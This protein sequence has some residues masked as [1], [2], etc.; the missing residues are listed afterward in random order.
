MNG[1][2]VL[3]RIRARRAAAQSSD[4]L[5]ARIQARRAAKM[6][7]R[8]A[9][10]VTQTRLT[11]PRPTGE[12][13][14]AIREDD[15]GLIATG[16]QGA[17]F[18]LSDEFLAGVKSLGGDQTYAQAL[19][20]E[21][22][23]L[24][25]FRQRHP[26]GSRVTEFAGAATTAGPLLRGANVLLRGALGRGSATLQAAKAGAVGGAAYGA[27]T[28]D[29]DATASLEE[30][31]IRRAGGAAVGGVIGGVAGG[32]V[33]KGIEKA[34]PLVERIARRVRGQPV[35]Q[36]TAPAV[37]PV[38]DKVADY[39][40]KQAGRD[41]R[42][43]T[44][45][46]E[47]V[48]A[49][50][51]LTGTPETIMEMSGPAMRRAGRAVE[52]FPGPGASRMARFAE[53]R[54]R[55][56]PADAVADMEKIMGRATEDTYRLTEDLIVARAADSRPLY[57]RAFASPDVPLTPQMEQVLAS[58]TGQAA[59][60]AAQRIMADEQGAGL[61]PSGGVSLVP[62]EG[63][64]LSIRAI[65]YIKKGL[66][67][68]IQR[69]VGVEGGLGPNGLRAATALKHS[70]LESVDATVPVYKA[71]RRVYGDETAVI[72]SID[73][74]RQSARKH[75][76]EIRQMLRS[77]ESAAD[78]EGFQIGWMS[79]KADEFSKT[80][81]T[82]VLGG[83]GARTA[84]ADDQI[85]AVMDDDPI[86]TEALL[87]VLGRRAGVAET[88]RMFQGS[89]T[90]PLAEDVADLTGGA[91][92]AAEGIIRLGRQ[93]GI[94]QE[95]SRLIARRLS[96]LDEKAAADVADALTRTG[97]DLETL[98][99]YLAERQGAAAARAGVTRQ[100]AALVGTS[101]APRR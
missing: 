12:Q 53:Q 89:R 86:K 68:V 54:G 7:E 75:P 13:S 42:T 49:L 70:L 35:T 30:G 40:L 22:A 28:A 101:L 25:Q 45:M 37:E 10:D 69:R 92:R 50:R 5:L 61:A 63:Q 57:E 16:I 55:N 32:V 91:S 20:N 87:D 4:P 36:G 24:A 14:E 59:L 78:R 18:G 43:P 93:G 3:D 34:A 97:V 60:K 19:Q 38:G 2:P 51:T 62:S 71:A 52:A 67:D 81:P 21:R 39:L 85:R 58:P 66:D 99:Q 46:L 47:D 83:R 90:T 80:G 100:P 56:A 95:A 48:R 26:V 11:T 9:A 15:R 29:P 76:N 31:V 72:K 84:H 98:L 88:N 44:Q 73:L 23:R 77:M 1:D 17:S 65:D 79:A 6:P 82:G 64:T 94:R 27:G 96:G 8:A 33:G 41:Q 74:G